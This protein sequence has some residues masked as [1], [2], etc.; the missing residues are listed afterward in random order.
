MKIWDTDPNY[1]TS[2][3]FQSW[4]M[5]Y[6]CIMRGGG[7]GFR[8]IILEKSIL[9]YELKRKDMSRLFRVV[10][11]PCA[12]CCRC[13]A[14]EQKWGQKPKSTPKEIELWKCHHLI[15][16]EK[17]NVT[18][19]WKITELCQL[20]GRALKWQHGLFWAESWLFWPHFLRYR[21]Q[22]CLLNIYLKIDRKTKL[23]VMTILASKSHINGHISIRVISKV[24][25][26]QSL[27]TSA[28]IN[29]NMFPS[30]FLQLF[31]E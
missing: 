7:A 18:I 8:P 20:D 17:N 13:E 12:Q 5:D 26:T 4:N 11:G 28:T 14:S 16:L 23:E 3:Y 24:S 21:L 15:C 10:L 25:V 19:G 29:N 9:R 6:N 30:L 27:V 1:H 31:E 2:V 22:I